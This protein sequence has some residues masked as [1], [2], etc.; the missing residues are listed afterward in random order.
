M[1][2]Y[3]KHYLYPPER[4]YFASGREF[5][6]V[7]AASAKI[8]MAICF[9]HAFPE[10]FRLLGLKGAQIVFIPSAVPQN[11][12][13]LLDLRT[14]ARAQDNQYFVVAANRVIPATRAPS[15]RLKTSIRSCP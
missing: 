5:S 11:Y 2:R 1:G 9:D 12:E 13:Y 3:R 6:V 8:G 4:R 15:C 7:E 10:L 14:R